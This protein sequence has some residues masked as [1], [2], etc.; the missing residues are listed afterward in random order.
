MEPPSVGYYIIGSTPGF[1]GRYDKIKYCLVL[2]RA[3][4]GMSK[5]LGIEYQGKALD[6]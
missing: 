5:F 4:G 6:T 2:D 3:Q 1:E